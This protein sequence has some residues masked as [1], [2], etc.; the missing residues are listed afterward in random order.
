MPSKLLNYIQSVSKMKPITKTKVLKLSKKEYN[1]SPTDE[2]KAT[3]PSIFVNVV[4]DHVLK[5]N[6]TE[7]QVALSLLSKLGIAFYDVPKSRDVFYTKLRKPILEKYGKASPQY[8][9][10][11]ELMKIT[12]EERTKLNKD[13]KAK[14][15]SANKDRKTYYSDD[16]IGIIEETKDDEDWATEAIGLML[17]SGTRP[18]ELLDRNKFK[19]DPKRKEWV[20]VSDIAKKR[21]GKKDAVTSRPIIGYTG[22]QFID[23]VADFR[24]SISDRELYIQS[25]S[26]KGQLKKSNAQILG[27]RAKELFPND[28][29]ITPKTLRKLYGNLSH[30]LYGGT[31]NLNVYLGEVL[32][33]DENDQQTSFSYS[34]VRVIL[35]NKK[36]NS[37]NANL[38]NPEL[39][40]KT[41]SLEKKN[42]MLKSE[43]KQV[44]ER[45]DAFADKIGE[46]KP[47]K[48]NPRNL[49]V[50]KK[51]QIVRDTIKKMVE[52]GEKI[53]QERVICASGVG[54]RV[55][56]GLVGEYEKGLT[57][58]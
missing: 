39:E 53:S 33:H 26:D 6:K 29:E 25:G 22:K 41:E 51:E 7:T 14:V 43:L 54:W 3:A 34:T 58:K 11:L 15:K 4:V 1:Y 52:N 46:S 47:C 35:G 19:V 13:Y 42:E 38:G 55:T 32:G 16:L 40:V 45:L 18:V 49:S 56:R 50:E 27:R 28:P 12:K 9:Q 30:A 24:E 21:E 48:P 37:D 20:I 57:K 8:I 44:N 23:A 36:S 5:L 31:S 2:K 10:T 17:A